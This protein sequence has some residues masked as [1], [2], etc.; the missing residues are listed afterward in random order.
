MLGPGVPISMTLTI[1]ISLLATLSGCSQSAMQKRVGEP[2]IV[3]TST[4]EEEVARGAYLTNHVAA[5]MSCHSERN[6]E[7]FAG[8]TVKG[9]EG[10]GGERWDVERGFPGILHATNITPQAI[11]AW[12][13][14]ELLQAISAGK[15]RD[16][17]G[18]FPI[19]PYPQYAKLTPD[20]AKSIVSYLRTVTP[21]ETD[22]YERK[23]TFVL[24]MVANKM[25]KRPEFSEPAPE[26]NKFE[27]GKY[28]ANIAGCIHCHTPDKGKV[29]DENA[30][31]SGGREFKMTTGTAIS[32]NISADEGFGIGYWG[33]ED[34][35][36]KFRA[37]RTD[38]ARQRDASPTDPN[39]PMPWFSYA[40]MSDE[41][42]SAIWIYIQGA[43]KISK[44]IESTWIMK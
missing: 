6:W 14:G 40:G 9:T 15:H 1:A 8:P 43:P 11:G 5:C 23:L 38:A 35:L 7:I 34:F 20:D 37:F 42:L 19:M 24:G 32:P 26:G 39:S 41:D 28:L 29:M 36:N 44:K 3:V 25:P 33:E 30:L 10:A 2:L 18:L 21:I 22:A 4:D 31:L 27:Q 13:D 17:Y 16:G 12:T